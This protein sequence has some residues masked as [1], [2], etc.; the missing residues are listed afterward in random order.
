[1]WGPSWTVKNYKTGNS[2][3]EGWLKTCGAEPTKC[4]R[5][6]CSLWKPGPWWMP[7]TGSGGRFNTS[8]RSVGG[9]NGDAGNWTRSRGLRI[10]RVKQAADVQGRLTMRCEEGT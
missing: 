3:T 10:D 2:C 1:M 9:R 8:K 4:S 5:T 6:L 7:W